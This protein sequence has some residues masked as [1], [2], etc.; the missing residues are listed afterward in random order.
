VSKL[1]ITGVLLAFLL[2]TAMPG[3]GDADWAK[4]SG[5]LVLDDEGFGSIQFPDGYLENHF[6]SVADGW[7]EVSV[8]FSARLF[9]VSEGKPRQE[10]PWGC[11]LDR[12]K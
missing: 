9:T 3:S 4:G 5:V 11:V 6:C 1:R 2:L 10:I 12:R 8:G 7:D